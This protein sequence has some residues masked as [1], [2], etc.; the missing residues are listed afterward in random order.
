[1]TVETA[2]LQAAQAAADLARVNLQR[3]RDLLATA[4][5]SQQQFDS[6]SAN[7][8][9]ALAQEANIQATIHKKTILAPFSGRLGIRRVNLGQTLRAE[10]IP[11]SR[12]RSLIRSMPIFI[13]R[14]RI[15]R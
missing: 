3:S 1:M 14:S 2:Q 9:Q 5:I 10:A 8:K 12:C 7:Y 11:S 6:D 15:F 4:T 13:C